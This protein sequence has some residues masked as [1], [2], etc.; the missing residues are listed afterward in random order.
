MCRGALLCVLFRIGCGQLCRGGERTGGA[1][2]RERVG[3][4]LCLRNICAL[5]RY[6]MG[7]SIGYADRSGVFAE[8]L[9]RHGG[10]V[11]R[12]E[13]ERHGVLAIADDRAGALG[14][15]YG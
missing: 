8:C 9:F 1:Q 7:A 3:G 11:Q 13:H 5:R 14:G 15:E 10:A 6:T 4:L 2:R 12:G